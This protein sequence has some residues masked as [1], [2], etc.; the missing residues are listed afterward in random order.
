MESAG[1]AVLAEDD[2]LVT[3]PRN[4]CAAAMANKMSAKNDDTT[5]EDDQELE[6]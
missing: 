2:P 5:V 3:R 6:L 4:F 1:K